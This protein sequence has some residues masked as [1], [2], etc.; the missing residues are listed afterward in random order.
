M[1]HPDRT[2]FMI[3]RRLPFSL[4]TT[5]AAIAAA[6]LTQLNGIR[7]P[8]LLE[9]ALLDSQC[10]LGSKHGRHGVANLGELPGHWPSEHVVVGEGL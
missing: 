8:V 10:E 1:R 4:S 3:D 6:L 9:V 2:N 7:H 5:A